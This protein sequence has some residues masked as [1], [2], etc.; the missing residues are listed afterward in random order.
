MA[1]HV[2]CTRILVSRCRHGYPGKC[3]HAP[4]NGCDAA[5]KRKMCRPRKRSGC[6]TTPKCVWFTQRPMR[7]SRTGTGQPAAGHQRL[8]HV[9]TWPE[10]ESGLTVGFGLIAT[11]AN[12]AARNCVGGKI[13]AP[14]LW[15]CRIREMNETTNRPPSR[16]VECEGAREIRRY[17]C[18]GSLTYAASPAVARRIGN[19]TGVALFPFPFGAP[20]GIVLQ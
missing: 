9:G 3:T 10:A 12:H 11:R 1:A 17:R 8:S 13:P 16:R 15:C 4:T 18:F 14:L 2:R 20:F 5:S 19:F 6:P 7:R